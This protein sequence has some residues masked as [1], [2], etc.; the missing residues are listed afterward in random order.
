MLKSGWRIGMGSALLGGIL[1]ASGCVGYRLGTTLPP[2]IDVVLIPVFENQTTE[3]L[4]EI[5]A[6][7]A[8]IREF[9]RD[10]TLSVGA[11][12]RA[13]VIL[14]VQLSSF[15]ME[16]LRFE[17]DATTTTEE[18]RMTVIAQVRLL[19]RTTG[20]VLMQTQVNGETD[21]IPSGDLTSAKRANLPDLMDD[22]AARIVRA[23]I[24]FW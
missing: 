15:D 18:Y 8:T 9:Q 12:D 19:E 5:E 24:E 3:P 17:R 11:E 4:L 23:A 20:N 2:G 14:D 21:F 10:G 7:Q 22:L 6:T 13:D 16:P 1:L